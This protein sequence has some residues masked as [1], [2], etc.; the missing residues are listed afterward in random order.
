MSSVDN[1]F[2]DGSDTIKMISHTLATV[3]VKFTAASTVPPMLSW[4]SW[5]DNNSQLENMLLCV[6]AGSE[7]VRS[8]FIYLNLVHLTWSESSFERKVTLKGTWNYV[9]SIA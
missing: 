5:F 2:N 6:V 8:T 3:P 1:I 7:G 4:N 9:S